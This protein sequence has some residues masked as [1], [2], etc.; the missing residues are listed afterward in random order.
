MK[1][2]NFGGKGR[3]LQSIETSCRD[4]CAEMAEPPPGLWTPVGRMKLQFNHI[5][6]VASMCTI[7]IVFARWRQCAQA[8]GPIGATHGEYD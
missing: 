2:F 4:S 6:Q 1:S 5:R 3:L 8:G 7:S